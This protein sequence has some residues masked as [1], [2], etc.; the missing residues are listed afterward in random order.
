MP[1]KRGRPLSGESDSAA[2]NRRR[3]QVRER[4]RQHRLRQKETQSTYTQPSV[5][6]QEQGDHIVNLTS[7][8]EEEAS[9]PIADEVA[10]MEAS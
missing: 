4:V 5:A 9:G 6:Q 8:E 1:V 2:V 3:E 10:K 7:V